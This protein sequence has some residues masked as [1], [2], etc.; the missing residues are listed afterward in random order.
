MSKKVKLEYVRY[1]YRS[2]TGLGLSAPANL[3]IYGS[4]NN[5]D[6]DNLGNQSQQTNTY[7]SYW[8]NNLSISGNY[9]YIK[10][11]FTRDGEFT[12]FS[13]LEVYGT[14]IIGGA[15]LLNMI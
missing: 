4:N 9:R 11:A 3:I 2:D 8:S 6:F 12:F 10:F 7:G 15:F 14:Y 13:E 1:H 5:I